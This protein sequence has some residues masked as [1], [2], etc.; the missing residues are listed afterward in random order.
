MERQRNLLAQRAA[1]SGDDGN[2]A[3]EIPAIFHP[4]QGGGAVV[5]G[6]VKGDES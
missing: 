3:M 5:V 1:R 6:V 4:L 2:L